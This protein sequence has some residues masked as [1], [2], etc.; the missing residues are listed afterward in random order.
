MTSCLTRSLAAVVLAAAAPASFGQADG[1]NN[2]WKGRLYCLAAWAKSANPEEP[3]S[4]QEA[5]LDGPVLRPREIP[6]VD[7][8][9][10]PADTESELARK[11]FGQ[12]L[13][14][15]HLL[16]DE[17]AE[18]AFR[19][20]VEIDPECA[21]AYWG[22]AM[23][24]ADRPGRAAYFARMAKGKLR[25]AT[26]PQVR[27]MV[28]VLARFYD[29][30]GGDLGPRLERLASGFEDLA[31]AAPND[32]ESKALYLRQLVL[33]SYRGGLELRSR[34]AVDRIAAE[35]AAAAPAHPSSCQRLFLW[36]NEKPGYLVDR[37]LL[38][39]Q[40]L[41]GPAV[42]PEWRF[43]AEAQL[44]AGQ[45]EDGAES[46]LRAVDAAVRHR[47]AWFDR[48]I[49]DPGF[50]ENVEVLAETLSRLG[51]VEEAL[52]L[53]RAM[54]AQP[55]PSAARDGFAGTAYA[56]GMR[57]YA[58]TCLEHNL[59]ARLATMEKD[60]PLHPVPTPADAALRREIAALAAGSVGNA[61]WLS[62]EAAL[63]GLVAA[64]KPEAAA[65]QFAAMPENRRR[66]FLP[67]ALEILHHQQAGRTKEAMQGFDNAFR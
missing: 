22:L 54:V 61:G 56:R 11:W 5:F 67:R 3:Q 24:N 62:P 13:S 46:L 39:P 10:F 2:A 28:G 51:R 23:V 50:H 58:Q 30:P 1:D 19:A 55:V 66:A 12:G 25:P 33:N 60:L 9:V 41:A 34:W 63:A 8:L 59:P 17:E 20:V 38:A 45:W 65:A 42:V 44:A 4:V 53:A 26:G 21:M 15:L 40:R 16:W 29:D 64:A 6:G 7:A 31:I 36:M 43:L 35:I 18:R 37:G 52:G 14:C 48:P 27:G 57:L 49:V 32:V 47:A